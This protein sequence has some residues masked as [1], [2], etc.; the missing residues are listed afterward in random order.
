MNL[1]KY[2]NIDVGTD[3]EHRESNGNTLP[4]VQYPFGNQSY[5]FQSNKAMGGWFY[6]TNASYTEG[7]RVSNQ[8]SPWLGDHGHITLLPFNGT[9]GVDLHSALSKKKHGPHFMCGHL[10]R[11]NTSFKLVPSLNGAIIEIDNQSNLESKLCIDCFTENTS[12]KLKDDTL[13]ITNTNIPG[14][15]YSD[16]YRKYYALKFNCKI[17]QIEEYDN[18]SKIELTLSSKAYR[19]DLVTSYIS[20]DLCEI[21]VTSQSCQSFEAIKSKTINAWEKYLGTITVNADEQTSTIFYSNLYRIFCFPRIISEVNSDGNEVYYNFKTNSIDSGVMISDVGFWDTYRTTMPLYEILIPKMYKRFSLAILNYYSSYGWLPRWLAPF[22]RGI[23]PSTLVDSIVARSIITDVYDNEQKEVAIEALLKNAD[24][25]SDDKLFGRENLKEFI[26]FG[27]IPSESSSETVSS[28]LD[29]YY[30]DYAIYKALES[31]S[32]EDAIRF[33][34]RSNNYINLFNKDTKLFERKSKYGKF[35]DNFEPSD[36]GFDFCESS[37][38]QNNLNVFHDI[39][40]MIKLFGSES[41]LEKRLNYLFEAEP[42]YTVGSY[43]FEI[44][45]MTEYTR[46]KDLG[47]FAISNQPSFNMPFWYLFVGN[48]QKF[49]EVIKIALQYF[50]AEADGYPGDEDNGSLAAWYI[51]V[52][53][54]MYPFCPVDG[55]I[56]FKPQMKHVINPI[57]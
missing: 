27:Y 10:D 48:D 56:N 52:N 1:L 7:I 19:M 46:Y 32:H 29:N 3:S 37:A 28:S 35:D 5:V 33:K 41:G 26:K 57:K 24:K 34:E 6:K 20:Y 11:Y 21:N 51:L 23:M 47:H 40:G 15:A 14:S 55:M 36:W 12:Y 8:P 44:H 50:T 17:S 39:E 49:E 31:T 38:W 54:G 13:F 42:S 53:I 30:C 43:G 2:V 25:V 45:E 9:Y 16:N 18:R 4:N 22:E